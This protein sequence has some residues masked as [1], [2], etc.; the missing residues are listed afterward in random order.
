M[1]EC[2]NT[3]LVIILLCAQT[4]SS[5]SPDS[6]GVLAIEEGLKGIQRDSTSEYILSCFDNA[7]NSFKETGDVSMFY[8]AI[9]DPFKTFYQN[10]YLGAALVWVEKTPTL[11][12]AN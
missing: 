5:Q 2:K 7:K 8:Q 3:V 1:S 10:G 12:C 11:S 6:L 9:V 4:L